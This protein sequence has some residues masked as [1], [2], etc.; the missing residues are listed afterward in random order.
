[1][2]AAPSPLSVNDCLLY[3]ASVLLI[4][5]G[6]WIIYVLFCW[7]YCT[8][9]NWESLFQY[10]VLLHSAGVRTLY[11]ATEPL[12]WP[13]ILRRSRYRGYQYCD[14]AATVAINIATEPLPWPSI[15]RRSR[16]RGYQSC[17]GAAT[18]AINLATEPLPWL[19][20]LENVQLW[21]S[22]HSVPFT[23]M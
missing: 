14:G 20:I 17:D 13:S 8:E 2:K 23:T 4:C 5:C 15:L 16:Y 21:R 19:S 11:I 12:P 10:L 3:L 22:R 7:Y 9:G 6:P 18:V 1:M